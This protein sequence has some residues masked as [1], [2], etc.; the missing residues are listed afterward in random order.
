MERAL[1]AEDEVAVPYDDAIEL[2][3]ADAG[4]LLQAATDETVEHAREVVTR[5]EVP[6]AGFEIGRD[7]TIEVGEFEPVAILRARVPISWHATEQASLFPYVE[8]HLELSSVTLEPPVTK[9]SLVGSY[10]PPFGLLGAAGDV[11]GGHRIAEA[12]ADRFVE[13]VAERLRQ[14]QP[15]AD[16]AAARTPD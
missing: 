14:L 6:I 5:L 13:L 11:A 2:L 12:A 15:S 7:V 10:E 1:Y 4:E 3:A 8:A 9:V 16:Q